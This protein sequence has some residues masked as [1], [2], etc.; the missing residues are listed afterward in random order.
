[1]PNYFSENVKDLLLKLL[2]RDPN[3]RL[4]SKGAEE[5]KQHAFFQNINWEDLKNLK[6]KAPIIPT[7]TRPDDL[8]N[9]DKVIFK[10]MQGNINFSKEYTNEPVAETP[11]KNIGIINDP[12][13]QIKN[14]T[15]IQ[16]DIDVGSYRG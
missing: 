5:I 3:Q 11:V 2:V 14:F 16:K 1:M 15:Y 9:F 7:L 6:I 12:R 8:R 13:N 4:G 10:K